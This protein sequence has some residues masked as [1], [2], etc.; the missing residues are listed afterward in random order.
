[1]QRRQL[2]LQRWPV[3]LLGEVGGDERRE[4]ADLT[5]QTLER[6]VRGVQVGPVD[7]QRGLHAGAFEQRDARLARHLVEGLVEPRRERRDEVARGVPD[8]VDG[9]LDAPGAAKGAG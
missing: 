9:V 8:Q 4:R 5:E 3:A 6:P 1:M 7:V 2:L